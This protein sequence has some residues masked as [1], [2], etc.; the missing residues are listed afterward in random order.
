MSFSVC[1][2]PKKID[3]NYGSTSQTIFLPDI[4]FN[5]SSESY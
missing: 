4:R 1:K 5:F 2:N 3:E